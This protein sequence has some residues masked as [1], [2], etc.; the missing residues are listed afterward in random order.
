M[1]AHRGFDERV[2]YRPQIHCDHERRQPG[3]EGNLNKARFGVAIRGGGFVVEETLQKV[4]QQM[5]ELAP[6][7]A[8]RLGPRAACARKGRTSGS[9]ISRIR[10][11]D[12]RMAESA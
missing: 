11:K 8:R 1:A 12:S 10:S 9:D 2:I 7:Q 4:A 3:G 6:L 5:G